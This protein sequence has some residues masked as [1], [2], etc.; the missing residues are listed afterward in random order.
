MESVIVA[1]I[2]VLSFFLPSSVYAET[3]STAPRRVQ[4][5][6]VKE[7][8]ER[9]KNAREESQRK[10]EEFIR[11]FQA[12]K[13]E[14]ESKRNQAQ[15]EFRRKLAEISDERKQKIVE[16]VDTRIVQVNSKWVEHWNNVLTRL[17][18]IVAKIDERSDGSVDTVSAKNAIA[19]AQNAVAAQAAKTYEIKI[20]GDETVGENT[21]ATLKIFHEDL[22]K[23]HAQV[24]TAREE[25]VKALRELKEKNEE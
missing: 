19:T 18:Q 1:A 15:G 6:K 4:D 17:S 22:R 12:R 13:K 7:S 10:R 11:S 14:A 20:E 21:R 8:V 16:N 24:K 2:L 23:V 5:V 25:V 9:F 3:N